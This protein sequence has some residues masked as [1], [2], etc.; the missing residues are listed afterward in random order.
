M[1]PE[2]CVSTVQGPVHAQ[3]RMLPVFLPLEIPPGCSIRGQLEEL[4]A[5]LGRTGMAVNRFSFTSP[6]HILP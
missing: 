3:H 2:I 4:K 1:F 6:S 5:D